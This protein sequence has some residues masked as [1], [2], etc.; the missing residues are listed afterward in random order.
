MLTTYSFIYRKLKKGRN[1]IHSQ[2][3]STATLVTNEKKLGQGN[4]VGPGPNMTIGNPMSTLQSGSVS[5]LS[6]GGGGTTMLAG[7]LERDA[8]RE[9][10]NYTA[11]V[12][13]KNM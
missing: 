10:E 5:S 3:H 11:T 4:A 13:S 2:A 6:N 1:R 12:R 9:R 7:S 8:Q